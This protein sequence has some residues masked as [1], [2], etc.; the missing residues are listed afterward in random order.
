MNLFTSKHYLLKHSTHMRP[1]S[2]LGIFF[3]KRNTSSN[4]SWCLELKRTTIDQLKSWAT[5]KR[6]CYITSNNQNVPSIQI[7]W[8]K[9]RH[10]SHFLFHIYN[11]CFQNLLRH[12]SFHSL[13]RP[14]SFLRHSS[15]NN[16]HILRPLSSLWLFQDRLFH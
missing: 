11:C 12:C 14:S 7:F 8:C 13:L 5:L 9:L 4:H 16:L 15:H 2:E 10:L 6:E 1:F 3:S